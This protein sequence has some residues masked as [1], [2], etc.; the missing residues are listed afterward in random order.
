LLDAARRVVLPERV[1][2]DIELARRVFGRFLE[3]YQE[4]LGRSGVWAIRVQ[5]LEERLGMTTE[6]RRR[7][8]AV[9]V[10]QGLIKI[11]GTQSFRLTPRGAGVCLHPETLAQYLGPRQPIAP[12]VQNINT[13]NATHVQSAQVGD[14]NVMNVTYS[15]VLTALADKIE[16]DPAVP[17]EQ[18]SKWAG[19]LREISTH[20]IS[21][22]V[23]TAVATKLA[24]G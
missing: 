7:G 19:A 18:K 16:A 3:V 24:G 22:A 17:P 21:V 6:Q 15:Q 23:V 14:G 12:V 13:L 2:E 1:N 8:V 20:P 11:M 10:Q 5:A 9:L 4:H